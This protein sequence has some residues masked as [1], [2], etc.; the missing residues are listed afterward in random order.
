MVITP[1]LQSKF[2]ASFGRIMKQTPPELQKKWDG[3]IDW[4]D[5]RSYPL[6]QPEII[7]ELPPGAKAAYVTLLNKLS[8]GNI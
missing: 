5:M 6:I 2:N 8:R 4:V 7:A 3:K 1:E